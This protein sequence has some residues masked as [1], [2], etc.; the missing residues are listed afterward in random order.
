[1]DG[2]ARRLAPHGAGNGRHR[3]RG[4]AIGRPASIS[5]RIGHRPAVRQSRPAAPSLRDFLGDLGGQTFSGALAARKDW[6]V[7]CNWKVY[8]DNYLEG[9][10][11]P[12]VHP[13]LIKEIDYPNHRTET[14]PTYSIQ[15]P[16]LKRPRR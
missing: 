2:R 15:H 4:A 11:I 16:P 12:I 1:M 13:S 8:V 3:V 14:R 6:T 9:Y 7:N 5:N 10:H